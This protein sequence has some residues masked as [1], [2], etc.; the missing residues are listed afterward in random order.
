MIAGPPDIR[1]H[2]FVPG[3]ERRGFFSCE[4]VFAKIGDEPHVF[5]DDVI[6]M[7]SARYRLFKKSAVCVSC[8]L[9][10]QWFAK[11]RS[12]A[13]SKK[14]GQWRATTNKWHFNLYGLS[15]GKLI[16]LTKDHIHPRSKGGPDIDSNFQ[17]LCSPCNRFK[18]DKLPHEVAT[19][20][21]RDTNRHERRRAKNNRRQK[22]KTVARG[23]VRCKT[24]DVAWGGYRADAPDKIAYVRNWLVYGDRLFRS[25]GLVDPEVGLIRGRW[26]GDDEVVY[27]QVGDPIGFG[28]QTVARAYLKGRQ[29]AADLLQGA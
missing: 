9:E 29:E 17:T 11:E 3:Y 28:S 20:P 6:D 25:D 1:S 2:G 23:E 18:S 24:I 19:S 8:G 7:S 27:M 22:S 16:M 5:D 26:E 12:A 10:G 21:P 14:T 13:F 4:E 15:G